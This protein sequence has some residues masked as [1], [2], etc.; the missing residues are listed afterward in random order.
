MGLLKQSIKG[1]A[2]RQK[3]HLIFE[4]SAFHTVDECFVCETFR[5]MPRTGELLKDQMSTAASSH[6][7]QKQ[8]KQDNGCGKAWMDCSAMR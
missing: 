1:R 7:F 2:G 6:L 8:Q 3:Q 4:P 5:V